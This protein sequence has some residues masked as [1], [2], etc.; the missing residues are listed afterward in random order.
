MLRS[1]ISTLILLAV[2]GAGTLVLGITFY[3]PPKVTPEQSPQPINHEAPNPNVGKPNSTHHQPKEVTAV[4]YV[5]YNTATDIQLAPISVHVAHHTPYSALKALLRYQ[6]DSQE[7]FCPVPHGVRLLGLSVSP[8]G[9]ATANFSKELQTEFPGGSRSEQIMVYSIVNTLAEFPNIKRVRILLE[10]Q[11]VETLGG[12]I[13]V[14]ELLE[15][16][17][18]IVNTSPARGEQ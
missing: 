17:Y 3:S 4:I 13:A 14:N 15:P 9:T 8:D 1:K 2:L 7:L 16:D 6:S 5:G 11:P 12:H 10:G 18:S